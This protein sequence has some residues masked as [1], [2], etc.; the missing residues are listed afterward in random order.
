MWHKDFQNV[1]HKC[2]ES[3]DDLIGKKTQDKNW[4]A[5]FLKMILQMVEK[6]WPS[7][8]T[9][10][11]C[12]LG[13]KSW[14]KPSEAPRSSSLSTSAELPTPHKTVV[15]LLTGAAA[16]LFTRIWLS[17]SW[18]SLK[19]DFCYVFPGALTEKN[20]CRCERAHLATWSSYPR[21]NSPSRTSSWKNRRWDR[22]TLRFWLH[23]W[24]PA[25]SHPMERSLHSDHDHR[26][27]PNV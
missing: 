27:T 18:W 2:W 9:S 10:C 17:S 11:A 23:Q 12:T 15:S 13:R 5:H 7:S 22:R 4:H 21:N 3:P 6:L 19:T 25:P 26:N 20:C 1:K 8:P 16:M 24:I 14:V